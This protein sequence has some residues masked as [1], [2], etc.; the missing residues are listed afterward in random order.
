[1]KRIS[2]RQFVRTGTAGLAVPCFIPASVLGADAPSKK[3]TIGFIGTGDHGTTYNLHR[4]LELRDA[5]VLMVCDVDGFRMRKAKAMVDAQYDNEDCAMTKDF[6]EVLARKDIDELM[7]RHPS[8]R[9]ILTHRGGESSVN[10]A[11][12]ARDFLTLQLPLH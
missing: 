1:M 12:M 11:V 9:F 7:T 10:G 8:V 6:R 5:K 2:R 4:Y 3:I